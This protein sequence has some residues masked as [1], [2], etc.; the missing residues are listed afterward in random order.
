MTSAIFTKT[1]HSGGLSKSAGAYGH[2]TSL[3][4]PEEAEVF[5][6]CH[7]RNELKCL[8][9]R[10]C[11][12]VLH[13]S[14]FE[15][16][17]KSG[18]KI[19]NRTCI[20]SKECQEKQKTPQDSEKDSDTV[21][22]LKEELKT[23]QA[24]LDEERAFK[25]KER[26]KRLEIEKINQE[27]KQQIKHNTEDTITVKKDEVSRLDQ[28]V[29]KLKQ[30][31]ED[32]R[33]ATKQSLELLEGKIDQKVNEIRS[34]PQP[35]NSANEKMI[36]VPRHSQH[37]AANTTRRTETQTQK[38]Y[39]KEHSPRPVGKFLG[40]NKNTETKTPQDPLIRSIN[41]LAI[42]SNSPRPRSE[43]YEEEEEKQNEKFSFQRSQR[44]KNYKKRLGQAETTPENKENGFCGGDRRA[45]LYINRVKRQTTEEMIVNYIKSKPGFTN[46]NISVKEL[47]SD[48]NK[49]KCFVVIAPFAK[50]DELYDT[51]FWPNSVGIKR[52][53]FAKHREFLRETD[54]FF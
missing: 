49:F 47:P 13:I 2:T 27:L 14:C 38:S 11:F 51:K 44:R 3:N 6:R 40:G 41:N 9:C 33:V 48:P 45:W 26:K 24:K 42:W 53:S 35:R 32:M 46:A 31:M 43:Y 16:D 34:Q 37:I 20:C 4:M 25:I 5:Y 30:Q 18:I 7:A 8:V 39:H 21:L 17:F 52:F 15:R 19:D 36:Q 1:N 12:G 22:Q 10:V 54:D 50:K 28:E 29:L 23:I